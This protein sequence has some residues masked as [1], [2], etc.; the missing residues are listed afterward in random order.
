MARQNEID[1][2]GQLSASAERTSIP[3]ASR[4]R[5]NLAACNQGRGECCLTCDCASTQDALGLW[6][7]L[8]NALAI[9]VVCVAAG[10]GACELIRGVMP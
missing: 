10:L 4:P 8:R 2:N 9:V 6:R 1:A 5:E 3:D 7:G